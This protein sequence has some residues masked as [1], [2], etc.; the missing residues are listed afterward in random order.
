MKEHRLMV[1]DNTAQE[2][3][4]AQEEITGERREMIHNPLHISGIT[5]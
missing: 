4:W 2:D 1:Y 5:F 3:V